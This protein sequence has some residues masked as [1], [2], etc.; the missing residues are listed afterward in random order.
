MA[1]RI[2]EPW[3]EE[4]AADD[5][6]DVGGLARSDGAVGSAIDKREKGRRASEGSSLAEKTLTRCGGAE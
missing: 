5:A 6:R 3:V 1:W 4:L 2:L